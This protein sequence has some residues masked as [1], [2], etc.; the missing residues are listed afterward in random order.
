MPANANF[1][2]P[3][4][5]VV[6]PA[7]ALRARL[8]AFYLP[9]FMPTPENDAWWGKGFTEWTNVTRAK[10]LFP[11][12]FQPR[13]PADLG[14]YDLR[15]PETRRE[16][17]DLALRYGIEGFCYWHYWFDGR[18]ILER[19][20]QE[21]LD[22]R[23]PDFPYCLAWANHNWSR[24]WLGDTT[25]ILLEQTY[26]PQDDLRHIRY[27]AAHFADPRY[28]RV[29]GR[30]LLAIYSPTEMD[31][32]RRTTDTFRAECVRLGLPEPF[33]IGLNSRARTTDMRTLGFDSTLDM[34]P[35]THVLPHID[36]DFGKKSRI[37]RFLTGKGL[38]R[39]LQARDYRISQAIM[40]DKA[41][42]YP[43]HQSVFTG[44]D[45]TARRGEGATIFTDATPEAFEEGL[46]RVI[47]ETERRFE[48]EERLVF[49]N[50]WNEW[51][52]AMYLEPDQ[53]YG[54]AFLEVVRNVNRASSERTIAEAGR[55]G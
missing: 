54:H 17:A 40:R 38:R 44:F 27:L 34:L 46:T 51:A 4:A 36:S 25:Q 42:D 8:L 6:S 32:A 41:P 50:A 39:P 49:V 37:K 43:H 53:R 30:P 11:N 14:F 22:S 31:D 16:Q 5:P 15:V 26:S 45:N 7:S 10:P 3:S 47:A 13:L 35:N 28:V 23:E 20:E 21:I 18:Q 55:R 29:N 24:S 19:V 33:L 12:H 2:T 9:Q 52:E 1:A 48:P